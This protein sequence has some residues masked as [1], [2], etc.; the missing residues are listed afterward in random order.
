MTFYIR[1]YILIFNIMWLNWVETN[2]NILESPYLRGE[3]R[4]WNLNGKTSIGLT[5]KSLV[6][7]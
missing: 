7:T 3:T 6:T 2:N 4:G 1:N 5:G